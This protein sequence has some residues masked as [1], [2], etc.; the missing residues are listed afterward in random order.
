[1][2][3]QS[4]ALPKVGM[5][6]LKF[7]V[8]SDTWSHSKARYRVSGLMVSDQHRMRL[9]QNLGQIH[10]EENNLDV[11]VFCAGIERSM[12]FYRY[13]LACAVQLLRPANGIDRKSTRLNSSH[14][15]IS[16]AV[17]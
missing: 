16:Y 3:D 6:E 1:M 2:V 10:D 14:L 11:L 15:V 7:S 5:P 9:P 8:I 17:F 12:A 4:K 13:A